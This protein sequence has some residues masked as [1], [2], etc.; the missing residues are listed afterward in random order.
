MRYPL[1]RPEHGPVAKPPVRRQRMD[2]TSGMRLIAEASVGVM[3][4]SIEQDDD[5]IK[6]QTQQPAP[7][8]RQRGH[9]VLVF[10]MTAESKT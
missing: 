5:P 6:T 10:M 1:A 2:V 7:S 3:D 8:S 9:A 4:A